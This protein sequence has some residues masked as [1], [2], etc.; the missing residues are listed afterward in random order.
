MHCAPGGARERVLETGTNL[1]FLALARAA[2]SLSARVTHGGAH[3]TGVPS[4]CL[5]ASPLGLLHSQ[6]L[7]FAIQVRSLKS[8]LFCRLRNVSMASF[9]LPFNVLDLKVCCRIA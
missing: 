5:A 2:Q 6:L 7:H 3:L 1:R 8:H 9:D 4:K